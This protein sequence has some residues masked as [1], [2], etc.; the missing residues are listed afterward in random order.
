M[1][2]MWALDFTAAWQKFINGPVLSNLDKFIT[3]STN[4]TFLVV[5]KCIAISVGI[6]SI[7]L[8]CLYL[9]D[10]YLAM[11]NP[12]YPRHKRSK[13]YL[14][15]LFCFFVSFIIIVLSDEIGTED[16]S[17]TIKVF[18]RTDDS[19]EGRSESEKDFL[20]GIIYFLYGLIAVSFIPSLLVCYRLG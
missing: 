13:W 12:F 9:L 8:N 14:M 18:D 17:S 3:Y 7:V 11:K 16:V 15:T 4:S 2:E 1:E 10:Y 5:W 6:T 20:R 19:A